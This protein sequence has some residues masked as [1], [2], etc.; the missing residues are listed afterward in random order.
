MNVGQYIYTKLSGTS[1][2]SALVGSRIYPVFL[3]QTAAYP[4]IVYRMT[5]EPN[6]RQMKTQAA[7]HDRATVTFNFW[8]DASQGANAYAALDSIDKAVRD[9]LDFVEAT[10]G[11]V[12][13]EHCH[14]DNSSDDF[15]AEAMLLLRTAT[16]TFI[17][18]N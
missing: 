10:A 1:A 9:A 12:T 4:A 16:Y 17:T 18:K 5:N 13:V 11:G 2:V 8:A 15:D 6:E 3:P 7:D 14:Y